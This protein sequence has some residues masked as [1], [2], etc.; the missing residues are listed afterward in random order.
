MANNKQH[1]ILDFLKDH[2]LSSSKDIFEG[3]DSNRSY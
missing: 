1:E 2:P 3:I